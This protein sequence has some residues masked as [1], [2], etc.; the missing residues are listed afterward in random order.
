MDGKKCTSNTYIIRSV[1]TDVCHEVLSGDP[2]SNVSET[3]CLH[4]QGFM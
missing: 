4:Y 1:H 2:T 3:D